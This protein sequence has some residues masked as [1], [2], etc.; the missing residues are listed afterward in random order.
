MVAEMYFKN[1]LE[2]KLSPDEHVFHH[3]HR[4]QS[5]HRNESDVEKLSPKRQTG[6][7]RTFRHLHLAWQCSFSQKWDAGYEMKKFVKSL[8][9]SEISTH[10]S[11]SVV[12]CQLLN[13]SSK[14][15]Q[16]YH[17]FDARS[18]EKFLIKY[19]NWRGKYTNIQWKPS[20]LNESIKI[21]GSYILFGKIEIANWNSP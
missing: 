7:A 10:Q 5:R 21:L 20:K 16:G 19:E 12:P 8:D 1:W 2:L 17:F 15:F 18:N 4:K 3:H 11:Q 14:F 6:S 13:S 9:H